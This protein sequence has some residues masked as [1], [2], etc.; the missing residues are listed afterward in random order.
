MLRFN[1]HSGYTSAGWGERD[2][3]TELVATARLLVRDAQNGER[4]APH[5]LSMSESQLTIESHIF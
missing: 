4:S 3:V 2:T 5:R 1:G